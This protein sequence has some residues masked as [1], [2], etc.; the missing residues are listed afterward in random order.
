MESN[1]LPLDWAF[2]PALDV[3]L[4]QYTLLGYLQRVRARFHEMKLY[5]HLNELHAHTEE[6][7][8]VQRNKEQLMRA[9]RGDLLGFDPLT[10]SSIHD[11]VPAPKD[12]WVIDEVITL[13]LPELQLALRTGHQL[14]EEMNGRIQVEPVGL[15]PLEARE[16]WMLLSEEREVRVYRYQLPLLRS[17]DPTDGALHIRTRYACS[18]TASISFTYERMKS[19]LIDSDRSMPNPAVFVITTDV[20]LPHVETFMPLAKQLVYEVIARA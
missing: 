20:P 9:L 12:M 11:A 18:Y 7:Q 14:R 3:E 8:R 15:M 2:R 13:A 19:D 17:A 6:L 4:K 16:G 10:G 1:W 5:P